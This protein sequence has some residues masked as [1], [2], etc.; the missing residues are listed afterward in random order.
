VKLQN[1]THMFCNMTMMHDFM[2]INN[3]IHAIF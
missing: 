1:N 2:Q 3:T